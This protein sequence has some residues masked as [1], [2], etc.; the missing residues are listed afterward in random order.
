MQYVRID[1]PQFTQIFET[2]D[3]DEALD[4][5]ARIGGAADFGELAADRGKTVDEA[6][7]ELSFAVVDAGDIVAEIAAEALDS[8]VIDGGAETPFRSTRDWADWCI[9]GSDG[10][11]VRALTRLHDLDVAPLIGALR[12]ALSERDLDSINQPFLDR[13]KEAVREAENLEGVR[14]ALMGV[15]ELIGDDGMRDWFGRSFSDGEVPHWG[16]EPR[17][18][19]YVWSWDD[20]QSLVDAEDGDFDL[21]FRDS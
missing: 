7:D 10:D 19:D 3:I 15:H 5:H 2:A 11:A 4:R 9:K 8:D 17:D 13:A 16:P 12:E 20:E 21:T 18:L 14:Q 6:K 1:N